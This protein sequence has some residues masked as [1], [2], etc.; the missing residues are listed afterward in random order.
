MSLHK[1]KSFP[2]LCDVQKPLKDA[3]GIAGS[4]YALAKQLDVNLKS[5]CRWIKN[6]KI[7]YAYREVLDKRLRRE[8]PELYV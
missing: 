7:S 2:K 3:V 4:K 5:L 8:F 6:R 1:S